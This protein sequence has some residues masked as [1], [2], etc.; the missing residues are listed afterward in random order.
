MST[1][2]TRSPSAGFTCVASICQRSLATGRSKRFFAGRRRD[3]C[4]ATRWL[5]VNVRWIVEVAG[6]STPARASSARIR[7]APQRG[8][9][10]PSAQIARSNLGSIRAGEVNGRRGFAS[11]PSIP[12]AR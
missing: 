2:Q 12:P 5:R 9:C 10:L 4:G 11:S 6:G 8:C 7:R 3:G 1:T